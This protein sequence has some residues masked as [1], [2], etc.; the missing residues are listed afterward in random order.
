MELVVVM[1]LAAVVALMVGMSM[2]SLFASTNAAVHRSEARQDV[3]AA[4]DEASRSIKGARP[5]GACFDTPPATL[6]GPPDTSTA[7][8]VCNRIGEWG[9]ALEAA[10]PDSLTVYSYSYVKDDEVGSD[11]SAK[12]PDKVVIGVSPDDPDV[13]QVV[14]YGPDRSTS[15]TNVRFL[16][17]PGDAP[18]LARRV[19]G[20]DQSSQAL[21]TY[22]DA[23]GNEIAGTGAG[24]ALG[25]G[26]LSDVAL[27]RVAPHV[28]YRD[29]QRDVANNVAFDD[30][31]FIALAGT[32]FDRESS[33]TGD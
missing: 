25:P 31:L 15:Y 1:S 5:L 20:L 33:W 23:T 29:R 14:R 3:R 7:A 21:F 11:L 22:Y 28:T 19:S 8:S 27:V 32:R 10:S 17:G 16:D 4:L 30:E 24:G 12:L 13:F 2:D 18:T 9:P 26:Q 6:T